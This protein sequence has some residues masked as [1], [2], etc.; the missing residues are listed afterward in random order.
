MTILENDW[1]PLLEEEFEKTYYQ[2]LREKLLAEYQSK[3]IYPDKHDIF[4]ALHYTSYKD[5]KVVIIG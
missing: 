4:N 5:A 1:A 2:H 3:D